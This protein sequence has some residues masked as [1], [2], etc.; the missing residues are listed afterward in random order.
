MERI[1]LP[2]LN[3]RGVSGG[4]VG[5]LA[6]NAVPAVARASMDFRLVPDQTPAHVRSLA[7]AHMR[8]QGFFVLDRDPTREE[9]LAHASILKVIWEDGYPASRADM[10][11]PV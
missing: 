10:S 7:L 5:A 11:L 8:R 3:V 2:A 6:T 1:M 4:G 9:R